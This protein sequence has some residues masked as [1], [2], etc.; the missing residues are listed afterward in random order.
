MNAFHTIMA[1]LV[2]FYVFIPDSTFLDVLMLIVASLNILVEIIQIFHDPIE[3][4]E[5][6]LNALELA[7]NVLVIFIVSNWGFFQGWEWVMI[8]LVM[9][10]AVMNMR[11][12]EGLRTL[13]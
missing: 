11:I 8:L 2:C 3:Y 10:S 1:A 12:F 13:I 6:P 5:N 7:G 9:L 4:V